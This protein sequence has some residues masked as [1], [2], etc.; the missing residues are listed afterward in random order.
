MEDIHRIA[1]KLFQCIIEGKKLGLNNEFLERLFNEA[2]HK[3]AKPVKAAE[4]PAEV[5]A[6]KP[7]EVVAEKPAAKTIKKP[8]KPDAKPAAKPAAT[9]APATSAAKPAATSAPAP[10][11]VMATKTPWGDLPEADG[12][13]A[14][15][16]TGGAGAPIKVWSSVSLTR[17]FGS[18]AKASAPVPSTIM[19]QELTNWEKT[20][21]S[22]FDDEF[23]L[24]HTSKPNS[25][26]I[27]TTPIDMLHSTV[28]TESRFPP[29]H[30]H[31]MD[32]S[33]F[34]A[35]LKDTTTEGPRTLHE[36]IRKTIFL[37]FPNNLKKNSIRHAR[38]TMKYILNVV[39][40]KETKE[41][42]LYTGFNIPEGEEPSKELLREVAV[43][44]AMQKFVLDAFKQLLTTKEFAPIDLTPTSFCLEFKTKKEFTAFHDE[45]HYDKKAHGF[46]SKE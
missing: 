43:L 27:K 15:P 44:Q 36:L 13:S 41:T 4:K 12:S 5:V 30:I 3:T 24:A 42:S 10:E 35:W 2:L 37:F 28:F 23:T 11:P 22:A 25:V 17:L 8:A 38:F 16:A 1:N 20:A 33:T 21:M 9:P 26:I 32:S 31:E 45:I 34:S 40:E 6:E 29:N 18:A 39:D 46:L 7:A 19:V 14:A